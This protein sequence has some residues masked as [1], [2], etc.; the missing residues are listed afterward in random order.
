MD[1]CTSSAVAFVRSTVSPGAPGS[2]LGRTLRERILEPSTPA[3]EGLLAE[4][5][6]F[7]PDSCAGCPDIEEGNPAQGSPEE[8]PDCCFVLLRKLILLE[9]RVWL[10]FVDFL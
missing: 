1:T 4:L 9:H 7:G 3:E 2:G 5:P 8:D 6:K 10:I